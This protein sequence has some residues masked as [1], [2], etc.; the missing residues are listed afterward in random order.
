MSEERKQLVTSLRVDPKIW[1][2][3]KVQAIRNDM[4]LAEVVGQALQEWIL[5][6]A[7][8][9]EAKEGK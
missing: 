8:E 2:E 3:A 4:T 9:R 5:R 6:K 7:K 1:K